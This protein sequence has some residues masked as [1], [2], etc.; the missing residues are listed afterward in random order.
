MS[1][2][3]PEFS[4]DTIMRSVRRR[5]RSKGSARPSHH[6]YLDPEEKAAA[7]STKINMTNQTTAPISYVETDFRD[8][9]TNTFIA[10]CAAD[11]T[12]VYCDEVHFDQID[13]LSEV[14]MHLLKELG[15]PRTLF[16][17]TSTRAQIV[18]D[19]IGIVSVRTNS[20]SSFVEVLG[21][22]A[23]VDVILDEL[24]GKYSE[25]TTSIEWMIGG[26]SSSVTIPLRTPAGVTDS[27]YPFIEEGVDQFIEDFLKSSENI[28]LL[29][30]EPGTGKSNFIKYIVSRS[31][32][33]ALITYDPEI[34]KKDGIFAMF[35]EGEYGS[36]IMEDA[37]TFLGARTDG[38]QM[39]AKFLNVGDGIVSMASKKLIFSTNLEKLDDI[40]PALLRP[41][42]CFAVLQFRKMDFDEAKQFLAD[43][44][45]TTWAP[46]PG[47]SYSLAELYN[48]T[49]Q[50]R[51][52]TPKRKVGFY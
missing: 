12:D 52:V 40:D 24:R 41:G 6:R 22:K 8:Y 32:Q 13:D 38:N 48:H 11:K 23:L 47:E 5:R 46:T 34:M 50:A 2:P 19:N 10:K 39:M 28:L 42:R 9:I 31:K 3:P 21:S 17:S 51:K 35:I 20:N 33:N 36:L 16:A 7:I 27:S 49:K 44:K 26:D 29:I 25:I 43:H 30:G 15:Y 37:D 4:L 18:V 14:V 1:S 45:I